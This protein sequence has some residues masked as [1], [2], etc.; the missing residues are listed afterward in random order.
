MYGEG[1][2]HHLEAVGTFLHHGVC[3]DCT[4]AAS[5][6]LLHCCFLF[7]R[8]LSRASLHVDP[9]RVHFARRVLNSDEHRPPLKFHASLEL[10]A[11][12]HLLTSF[13]C[14]RRRQAFVMF[15]Q[16]AARLPPSFGR[17]QQIS[18]TD[19][20]L[21]KGVSAPRDDVKLGQ[22][23][24]RPFRGDQIGSHLFFPPGCLSS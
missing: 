3:C 13:F 19:A 14:T 18:G 24:I 8:G 17:H 23:S 6:W 10:T 20:E 11:V 1:E 9:K 7:Y 21:L 12:Q 5:Y 2:D 4:L 15:M 16:R 22:N